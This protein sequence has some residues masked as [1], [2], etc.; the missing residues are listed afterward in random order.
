MYDFHHFTLDG[1]RF[2]DELLRQGV[3]SFVEVES[4]NQAAARLGRISP[5]CREHGP[6]GYE[7]VLDRL[8]PLARIQHPILLGCH[9]VGR[10]FQSSDRSFRI[11]LVLDHYGEAECLDPRRPHPRIPADTLLD[12]GRELVVALAAVAQAGHQLGR[13]A[14]DSL[15]L[16]KGA[17]HLRHPAE[18]SLECLF[19]IA[20]T[21]K[22]AAPDPWL[23]PEL[24]EGGEPQSATDAYAVCALLWWLHTGQEPPL[25]GHAPTTQG[26]PE[27]WWAVLQT[28][29]ESRP[30][31]RYR[32]VACLGE[33]LA[34]LAA[35]REPTHARLYL[36]ARRAQG[37]APVPAI[38]RSGPQI[39]KTQAAS[40][41][42]K[43][44][45]GPQIAKTQAKR[46]PSN[47]LPAERSG[48]QAGSQRQQ[49]AAQTSQ[50]KQASGNRSTA[51]SSS[52]ISTGA[53]A[54]QEPAPAARQHSPSAPV[55]A[56]AASAAATRLGRSGWLL[57]LVAL[58]SAATA[59][60]SVWAI[61]G[62]V[63][64][65]TTGG[66]PAGRTQS[67][68]GPDAPLF[69]WDC[70]S[71]RGVLAG[72][73]Y[74]LALQPGC[75]LIRSGELAGT[76]ALV[77]HETAVSMVETK[78]NS[79]LDLI[80]RG[81][82]TI[83]LSYRPRSLPN[84]GSPKAQ[85]HHCLVAT[86]WPLLGLTISGN[87]QLELNLPGEP[88]GSTEVTARCLVPDQWQDLAGVYDAEKRVMALYWNGI[89]V[90]SNA[91]PEG[92][93]LNSP[94]TMQVWRIGRLKTEGSHWQADGW[95]DDVRLYNRALTAEEVAALRRR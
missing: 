52:L 39:A 41:P 57:V 43:P 47:C 93:Q 24:R 86:S 15:I 31:R 66:P 7:S 10:R 32:D 72:E 38:P 12:L 90:A 73:P 42:V 50:R 85:S 61:S 83:A 69:Y 71:S 53:T 60:G 95:M 25:D 18:L 89:K 21:P 11:C 51:S 62:T 81:S 65:A 55:V 3:G 28:G 92:F 29:L 75:D 94:R 26:V 91:V 9:A 5:P 56:T 82:F 14:P 87:S 33:D 46:S 35:H 76:V 59:A 22:G 34:A 70:S 2:G 74:E 49:R 4:A 36:A 78:E 27:P 80:Y 19:G 16:R 8:Q 20:A 6:L 63:P 37:D 77:A 13:L 79:H 64:P 1:H 48:A 40:V 17:L 45:S 54:N 84:K 44:R 68:S 67:S 88:K 58:I 23:A 30:E